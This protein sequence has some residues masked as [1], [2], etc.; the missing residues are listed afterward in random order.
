MQITSCT[1]AT[2][3]FV[4]DGLIEAYRTGGLD[5][6]LSASISEVSKL[7][8]DAA[9]FEKLF[10]GSTFSNK[11]ASSSYMTSLHYAM[12]SE[13]EFLW[14]TDGDAAINFRDMMT[15]GCL[16]TTCTNQYWS[17][18]SSFVREKDPGLFWYTASKPCCGECTIYAHGVQ[19]SYWPTPA[20]TPPVTKLVDSHNHT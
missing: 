3:T 5:A 13:K 9:L 19:L 11:A 7:N 1:P 20:P 8:T 12:Q 14:G 18:S 4:R 16:F 15:D 2:W 17:Q 10:A 6:A